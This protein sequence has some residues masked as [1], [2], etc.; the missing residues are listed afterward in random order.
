VGRSFSVLPQQESFT[1]VKRQK[2]QHFQGVPK[3]AK[4]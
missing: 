4:I 3:D 2:M 1:W